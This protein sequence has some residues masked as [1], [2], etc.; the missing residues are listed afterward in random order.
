VNGRLVLAGYGRD[1]PSGRYALVRSIGLFLFTDAV[2]ALVV[3]GMDR[4]QR[5]T[6]D[7][8]V[9]DDRTIKE[10]RKAAEMKRRFELSQMSGVTFV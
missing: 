7:A 1:L 6:F 8:D 4:E 5:E 2:Y 9:G 3:E 10:V